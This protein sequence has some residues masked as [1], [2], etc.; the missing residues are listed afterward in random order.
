MTKKR[1]LFSLPFILIPLV[2]F[3]FLNEKDAEVPQKIVELRELHSKFLETQKPEK[4]NTSLSRKD[5]IQ[6]GLPPN[7]YYEML[8]YLTMNPALGYP[9]PNKIKEIRENLKAKRF[10]KTPGVEP[11]NPWIERGPTNVG[12]RTRVLLF[13]PNDPNGTRVFA[14]AISGGLWV[15]DDITNE[16]SPWEKVEGLPSNMNISCITVDPRD[17]NT[18][19][20]GTG[21][22]YTAG[23]VVGTGVFKTSD[24]GN[25]W[26]KVLDVEDFD[27]DGAGENALVVGGIH[28]INDIIAWDNGSSTEI[29]IGVTTH[30][31]ANAQHPDNFLGFFDRGL[32]GSTDQGD[33][34]EKL[35]P[36]ESFNDFEIDAEG[37]L[38]VVTTNSPGVGQEAHG[39]EIF[40]RATGENTAFT[41]ITT[42]PGVLRTEIEASAQN[43]DK[44][45]VLAEDKETG[46]TLMWVTNNSFETIEPLPIP[47]DADTDIP[48]NDFARGQA[49]YNL[50]IQSDP[51][52]D[53]IL[54]V[55]GIDLFRSSTGGQSWVQISKWANNNSL[56]DLP[57]SLVHADHHVMAFRP[58][59]VNQAVFGHDG[60]VS[61]ATDLA[62]AGSADVFINIEK[63]YITTQFYSIAAAPVSF[64]PGDYFLGGT[65]DNGTQLIQDSNPVSVGVLGGDGAHAFYDQ[66]NTDY[67]IANLVYN[68]LIVL[69]DYSEEDYR[70]IADNDNDEGLFINPQALDSNLDILYSNGPEGILYRYEGLTELTAGEDDIAERFSLPNSLLTASITS[71]TV[72]PYTT[73]SST[74]LIGLADGELLRVT[75]ADTDPE[76]EKIT[77]TGFLGSISDVEFGENENEILI[78]FYNYGVKNIWFTENALEETVLWENKEGDL[79]DMPVLSIL[80]NPLN[81][82]EVIVG[83]E[84]GVWATKNFSNDSPDW[85]QAYNGMSDVKVTDLDLRRGDNT[86]FAASYGR[87]MYTA[88]FTGSSNPEPPL[89]GEETE[90]LVI[91]SIS[92]G[93]FSI[94]SENDLGTITIE[95]FS[96]IGKHMLTSEKIHT[97]ANP[98]QIDLSH[99]QPGIYFIRISSPSITRVQ[100]V[101]VN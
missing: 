89:P 44:F 54:Y 43:P 87:G 37:N 99:V 10:R 23:D 65:Q 67:F 72:S 1:I 60:G 31:Y 53:Q 95:V 97:I 101:I 35:I 93:D 47:N 77:G 41:Q 6:Q 50:M 40:M 57:V 96:I 49:F 20:I 68:N 90:L 39:G 29:F 76:W 48:P 59:N 38:W 5:K 12:G 82:E 74:L 33:S 88:K 45:Y 86:I 21:E 18:W 91:P 92:D 14:G 4:A 78:T 69:Y 70:I 85:E 46:N 3:F 58:G 51:T 61:F 64:A 52:N 56:E 79:P 24:G 84:L 62:S 94:V 27:T 66:V 81:E 11:E 75:K 73:E 15:N 42:I 17:S 34:W 19:Y 16:D 22:Q 8:A 25:T 71:I 63:D 13:D 32:Y 30:I 26:K 7:Q 100:K 36:E 83:T 28:Y 55:G 80:K 9:Q 2:L 98:A